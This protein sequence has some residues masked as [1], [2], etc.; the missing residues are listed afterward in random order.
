MRCYIT[1]RGR[2]GGTCCVR[3]H[4]KGKFVVTNIGITEESWMGALMK[5]AAEE[6]HKV[7]RRK[8]GYTFEFWGTF[9]WN[10]DT[11]IV[12]LKEVEAVPKPVG[13]KP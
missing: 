7:G 10:E 8:L 13:R 6:A 5:K 1:M 12:K 11:G 2:S 4:G 3:Y 9:S